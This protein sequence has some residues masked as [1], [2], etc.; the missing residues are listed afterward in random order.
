MP[1][2]E[3]DFETFDKQWEEEN[4]QTDVLE[5]VEETA[6]EVEEVMDKFED[7]EDAEHMAEIDA[8]QDQEEAS[9]QNSQPDLTEQQ[10]RDAAFAQLRRERDEAAKQAAF[11]Q[12]LADENGMTVDELKKRYEDARLQEE[13]E[14][15]EIPVEVLQRLKQ[16]E[17]ENEAIKSQNFTARFNAEVESTIQKYNASEDDVKQTFEYAHQNGLTELLKSG[18]TTF[19]AVHKLAHMDTMIESQVK[20]AL[21]DDLSKK[22]KRQQEATLPHGSGADFTVESLEDQAAADAK[23]IIDNGW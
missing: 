16:L 15:Q 11:L 5:E 3:F 12:Q 13:A 7:Q 19:E 14:K 22:K 9:D 2:E 8:E 4:S 21:Q 6:E 17:S 10:K 20:K 18:T 23:K 1:N